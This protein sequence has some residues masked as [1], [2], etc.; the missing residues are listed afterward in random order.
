ME[1]FGAIAQLKDEISNL[2]VNGL[3]YCCNFP[4]SKAKHGKQ[5]KYYDEKVPNF[6]FHNEFE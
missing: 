4:A 3:R 5:V 6:A 2:R 1:I